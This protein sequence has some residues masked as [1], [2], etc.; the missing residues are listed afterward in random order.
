MGLLWLFLAASRIIFLS[1]LNSSTTQGTHMSIGTLH[2]TKSMTAYQEGGR[3]HL[4]PV[5]MKHS[6]IEESLGCVTPN[7]ILA[8]PLEAHH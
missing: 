4:E 8:Q 3:R 6:R 2:H 5:G 7:L 1:K